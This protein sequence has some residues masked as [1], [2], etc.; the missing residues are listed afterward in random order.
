MALGQKKKLEDIRAFSTFYILGCRGLD[1]SG[2]WMP[3]GNA[4]LG[5]RQW[6]SA[7]NPA[8]NWSSVQEL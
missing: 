5:G 1:A 2:E 3:S 7:R 6:R 8:L 4:W